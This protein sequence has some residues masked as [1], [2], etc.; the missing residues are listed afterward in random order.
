MHSLTAKITDSVIERNKAKDVHQITD[1][2]H[3]V[4]FRYRTDRNKGS[5]FVVNHQGGKSIWRK[6]GN[7]P[8][9]NSKVLFKNLPE[10]MVAMGVDKDSAQVSVS[11]LDTIESLIGWYGDRA[12]GNRELSKQRR[13]AIKCCAKHII[14]KIGEVELDEVTPEVIDEELIQPLVTEGLSKS[15]IRQIYDLMRL[16]FKQ[17]HKLKKITVNPLGG[18]S[19]SDFIDGQIKPKPSRLHKHLLPVVFDQIKSAGSRE[20][21]LAALMLM[22]G[23]RIGETKMIRWDHVDWG[24]KVLIIPAE[25]TK[26][27]EAHNIPLTNTAIAVL[28][29]YRA[30]QEYHGYKGFYLFPNGRGRHISDS[31]ASEYIRSVSSNEWSAHDLRKLA[32]SIWADL[33][34]DYFVSERLLNHKMKNLDQTY[35]HTHTE[36]RKR[37]ALDKYHAWLRNVGLG[38]II[39]DI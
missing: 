24:D 5:W 7:Y 27:K 35:I 16:S 33:D 8:A 30:Y 1:V 38:K 25:N 11:T 17:A 21:T 4:K 31:K 32:R 34:I 9:I 6:I 2:R 20:Q 13:S 15:Y 28:K 23:T 12:R 22:H 18:V 39:Q 3:P 37:M 10:I 36:N 29:R 19:F 14:S 26:T